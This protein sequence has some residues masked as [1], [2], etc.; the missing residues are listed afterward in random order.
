[1]PFWAQSFPHY[2]GHGLM[3]GNNADVIGGYRWQWGALRK[4]GD[5]IRAQQL[6]RHITV[7]EAN[8]AAD[9]EDAAMNYRFTRDDLEELT[10]VIDDFR[11]E[12][13]AQQRH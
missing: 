13:L 7:M 10:S 1:M 3:T 4:L 5:H 9:E 2:L 6:W 11:H 8:M 12:M